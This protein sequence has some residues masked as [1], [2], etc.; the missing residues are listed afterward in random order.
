M[1]TNEIPT[2]NQQDEKCPTR[3]AINSLSAK[4]TVLVILQLAEEP[5]RFGALKRAI[6]GISQKALTDTLKDLE[7]NGAVTRTVYPASP[8]QVEYSLTH[9]GQTLLGLI[10]WIKEWADTNIKAE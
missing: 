8:P 5:R 9:S 2:W 3:I 6:V 7:K 4:W 10:G 1:V